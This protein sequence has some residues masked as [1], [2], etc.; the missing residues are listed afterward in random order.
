[1][2]S[3]ELNSVP[4][5]EHGTPWEMLPALLLLAGG[6][7]VLILASLLSTTVPGQFIVV[8]GP[9]TSA[10][11]TMA[12]VVNSGGALIAAGGFDN[13]L[14]A[15]SED[16]GFTAALYEAGAW[17]VLPAPTFLGCGPERLEN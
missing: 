5:A 6:L 1:M 9:G 14:F 4:T 7:V 15:A 10:H 8:T 2:L 11:S 12:M 16:V 3:S 17:V 13:I